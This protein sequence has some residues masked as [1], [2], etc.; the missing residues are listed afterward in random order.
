M[1]VS[2]ILHHL[3]MCVAVASLDSD[4]PSTSQHE[5]T[6]GPLDNTSPRALST[7]RLLIPGPCFVSWV[8][9][10]ALLHQG[11]DSSNYGIAFGDV[12]F[13]DSTNSSRSAFFHLP[14]EHVLQVTLSDP[15]G[16]IIIECTLGFFS[17]PLPAR[18]R[19]TS[20]PEFDHQLKTILFK[21]LS[22]AVRTPVF[23]YMTNPGSLLSCRENDEEPRPNA[24]FTGCSVER[25][26][27]KQFGEIQTPFTLCQSAEIL[28]F[29]VVLPA[30][31]RFTVSIAG[32]YP[33]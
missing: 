22:S 15:M 31:H 26:S 28:D 9:Q 11:V 6:R 20:L 30:E 27:L 21:F 10:E 33:L 2:S 18:R 16:P 5:N 19:V 14:F 12:P 7:Q 8:Y 32:Y 24:N 17:P 23:P 25:F 13:L 1:C 29:Q 3:L 4:P